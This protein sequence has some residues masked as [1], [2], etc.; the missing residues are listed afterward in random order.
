MWSRK[1]IC[2]CA[3]MPRMVDIFSPA[4]L[5]RGD[6]FQSLLRWVGRRSRPLNLPNSGPRLSLFGRCARYSQIAAA[7]P[8]RTCA[9]RAAVYTAPARSPVLPTSCPFCLGPPH[10]PLFP[11]R[12]I[13]GTAGAFGMCRFQMEELKW[14]AALCRERSVLPEHHTLHDIPSS[15]TFLVTGI[16]SKIV[17]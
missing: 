10:V 12:T 7:L 2:A 8:G 5:C 9:L 11:T 13:R 16:F 1:D 17:V 15:L 4:K 14:A 3:C 6:R